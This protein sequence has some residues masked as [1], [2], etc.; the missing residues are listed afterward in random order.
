MRRT[1]PS[2]VTRSPLVRSAYENIAWVGL[3]TCLLF[4]MLLAGCGGGDS[5]A[6][7]AVA[8]TVSLSASPISVPTGASTALTWSSTDANGCSASGSWS[9]SKA[10]SG[11]ET[12]SVGAAIDS[13]SFTLTCRGSGGTTSQSVSVT[14]QAPTPAP[15]M[16]FAADPSTVVSGTNTTLTWSSNAAA[17]TASGGWSG[18]K[19]PNGTESVGPI[20][21]QTDYVL[22]C[23][24]PGSMVSTFTLTVHVVVPAPDITF[25]ADPSTVVSGTNTTLTWSSN[26]A[27]CTASGGWSGSKAP[28]GTESVGPITTQTDYV[29]RCQSP[30]SLVHVVTLTVRVT[31]PEPLYSVLY[32]FMGEGD[33]ENPYGLIVDEAGNLYGT[34]FR[35][36]R[37]C[38]DAFDSCG[39]VFKLDPNGVLTTLHVFAGGLKDGASPRAGLVRDEAGNLYGGT[40]LGGAHGSGVVFKLDSSGKQTVLHN[41]T[42]GADGIAPEVGFRDDAGNLYGTTG[43]NSTSAKCTRNCGTVF[44]LS[45]AGKLTTLYTFNGHDGDEPSTPLIGDAAG[46]LYGTTARGGDSACGSLGCG[47]VFKL[48][49]NGELTTMHA[50]QGSDGSTPTGRLSRDQ[51]GNLYGTTVGGSQG[52]GTVYKLNADGRMTILISFLAGDDLGEHPE[53]GVVL[54]A[55]GNLYAT[56]RAGGANGWGVILKYDVQSDEGTVVHAFTGED[57]GYAIGPLVKGSSGNLYGAGFNGGD[58][59]CFEGCGVVFKI[60][61]P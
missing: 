21:A 19:A 43:L 42:E 1:A 33:G 28:T 26:A 16:T 54:G 39:T 30:G 29:L 8:P 27:A 23:Q 41:F 50:F 45:T 24:S 15:D 12:I 13:V 60:E 37:F 49:P 32:N 59:A 34:T 9:G 58:V 44:K 17:C 6:E 47:T 52:F 20:T 57:G 56:T 48:A 51:A 22:S 10:I 36:G 4:A 38:V 55:S 46:N 53:G 40:Y 61:S 11:T 2:S 14:I 35:G 3:L 31:A 7:A 18:S 5:S 25:R